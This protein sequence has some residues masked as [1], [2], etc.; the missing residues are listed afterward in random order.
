[1]VT[2]I[3]L[4]KLVKVA[5]RADVT[6]RIDSVIAAT[7]FARDHRNGMIAHWNIDLALGKPC[8]ALTPH[9]KT[10]LDTALRTIDDLLYFIDNHYTGIG[11][12]VYE[13]LDMLGGAH[14]VIDIVERG[15]KHR[16]EQFDR[17]RQPG[18]VD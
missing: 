12:T 14:S 3:R 7:K 6:A 9:G 15:L 1:V 16:D 8:T 13:H 4:P 5:I 2:V 17:R 18:D 11:R 10:N